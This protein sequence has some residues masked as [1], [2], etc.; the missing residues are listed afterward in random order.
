MSFIITL[1][2][3]SASG[4]STLSSKLSE[5]GLFE[6]AVS[7]TTRLPRPGEID[8]VHY[9]FVSDEEFKSNI[10]EGALLEHVYSHNAAYGLPFAEVSRILDQGKSL[11]SVLDPV[12][13]AS[14]HR[15]AQENDHDIINAFVSV[16]DLNL[17]SRFID[18]VKAK[19][20]VDPAYDIASDVKRLTTMLSEETSWRRCWKWDMELS[21][22]EPEALDDYCLR[23][24]DIHQL[25]S[26]DFESKSKP[27]VLIRHAPKPDSEKLINAI[28][29][30]LSEKMDIE[31]FIHCV[32]EGR[33]NKE[34]KERDSDFLAP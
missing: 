6:E 1:T 12:G 10:A 9:H 33:M 34:A 30:C 31:T 14:M 27:K 28:E 5:T 18:R 7:M 3:M 19:R 15:F 8:G 32:S 11:V 22:N 23:F 2:G 21:N 24:M 26:F 4:K 25:H 16:S 20:I 13:A 29:S 17:M